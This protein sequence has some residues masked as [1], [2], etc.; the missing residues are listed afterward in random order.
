MQK[1]KLE[2]LSLFFCIFLLIDQSV[3][4][5]YLFQQAFYLIQRNE[6]HLSFSIIYA[7]IRYTR[8]PPQQACHIYF[9]RTP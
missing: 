2:K 7:L 5:T 6:M 4:V 9:Y 1:N 8:M 3:S